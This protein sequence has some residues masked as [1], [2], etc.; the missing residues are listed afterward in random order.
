MM[1]LN[2]E[3]S[4]YN[5]RRYGKP[6]IARVRFPDAKGEF[7]WGEWVGQPGCSGLLMLEAEPG[8]VVARGQ[9]D[10]RK[11]SNS[12]PDF[13]VV[14]PSGSLRGVTKAEAY[15]HYHA[16]KTPQEGPLKTLL[17]EV[18]KLP[19]VEME[20]RFPGLYAAWSRAKGVLS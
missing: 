7:S 18:G 19:M 9:R 17:T 15:T 13:F 11:M 8:D 14:E 16:P 2:I 3:T 12:A 10:N 6:W 5:E 1:K 4:P 20:Q